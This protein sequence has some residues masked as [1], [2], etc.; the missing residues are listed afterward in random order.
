MGYEKYMDYGYADL[1]DQ[2]LIGAYASPARVYGDRMDHAGFCLLA[3]E[4]YDGRVP[5]GGRR[6]RR[7]KLGY[8]RQGAGGGE[9]AITA[10]VAACINACDGYFL[11]DMIHLKK[12]K[13]ISGLMSR[14]VSTA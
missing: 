4:A 5:D 10:S 9:P 3:K 8:R 12:K 11:F 6:P 1:M 2:M 13:P 7:G 14:P